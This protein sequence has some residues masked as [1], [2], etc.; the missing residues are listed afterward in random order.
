MRSTAS[1]EVSSVKAVDCAWTELTLETA[2]ATGAAQAAAL[3]ISRRVV[4]FVIGLSLVGRLRLRRRG[5]QLRRHAL[6]RRLLVGIA[7]RHQQVFGPCGTEERDADRKA[8]DLARGHGEV[9][10]ARESGKGGERRRSCRVTP[11]GRA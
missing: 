5:Y 3:R 7:H 10:I 11:A 9:R 2:A 6:L 4:S 1:T 8:V